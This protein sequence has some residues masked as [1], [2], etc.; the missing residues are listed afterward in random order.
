MLRGNALAKVD[1]KGR[2][3]L[4]AIFRSVIEPKYGNE[5]FVTSLRGESTRIY[6]M[7]VYA[8]F[9]ERLLQSSSVQPLVTK[10]RNALNYFGQRAVMDA[11]G[12]IL[13][14][15]LLRDKTRLDG[16]VAVLG[17]QDYL[18]VWNRKD[19]EESLLNNP[20]TED[21]LVELANLGF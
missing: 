2:L 18:E 12:R 20:L 16:E 19:V 9:E 21:E 5:F 3:K 11:Q 7:D 8:R 4:P 1:G 10:L 13:I 14:H 15:P 17:Q 6:P